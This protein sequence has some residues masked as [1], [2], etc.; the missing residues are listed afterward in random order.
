MLPDG[1]ITKL[2]QIPTFKFQWFTVALRQT[3]LEFGFWLFEFGCILV[4][5]FCDFQFLSLLLPQPLQVCVQIDNLQI[6]QSIQ[7]SRRHQG[8]WADTASNHRFS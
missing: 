1:Q 8:K 6:V 3:E 5:G 4:L 7:Q 2:K